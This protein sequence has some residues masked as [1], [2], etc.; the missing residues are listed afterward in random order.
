MKFVDEATILVEAGK[1]GNGCLS[2]RREKYIP[3]GGPDGGDGGNGGSVWLEVDEGLNTLADFRHQRSFKAQ[4]GSGGAGRQRTGKAG[5]DVVIGVP[6]G[7]LAYDTETGELLGDLTRHGQRVMVAR[8]GFHGLGNT[9]YKSSTNRAP[10]QTTAGKPGESRRLRLELRVLADVGVMGMPNAGKSSL[11]RQVSAARPK[12]AGYPFSTLYPVLGVVDMGP[13]DSFTIAD[14]PGLVEG[15]AGGAGL[16][17]RFLRHLQRARLLLHMVDLSAVLLEGADPAAD[18]QA[19]EAELH[20]FD[21]TLA[22]R[23]RWLVFNKIDVLP[24]EDVAPAVADIVAR[25]GWE[26]PV[27][28]V[29]AHSGAGC[30]ELMGAIWQAL[31]E[32]PAPPVATD[33]FDLD[34]SALGAGNDDDDDDDDTF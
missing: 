24:A 31:P 32:L 27:H 8:G 29:S 6:A 12:V 19:V 9:R 33:A 7:T 17:V 13:G 21:P 23:P 26:G 20:E 15:A 5:E 2:F 14:L 3:M 18:F 1:G 30:R 4:N 16:G 28:V 22:Q 25:L 34:D 10:R 11:V